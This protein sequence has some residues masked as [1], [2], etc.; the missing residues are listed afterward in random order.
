MRLVSSRIALSSSAVARGRGDSAVVFQIDS[1]S[2]DVLDQ[3]VVV[4][5]N[6]A[7]DDHRFRQRGSLCLR[8]VKNIDRPETDQPGRGLSLVNCWV[9]AGKKSQITTAVKTILKMK[10]IEHGTLTET[11]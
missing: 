10:R 2:N 3:P 1:L 7:G 4:A 9:T 11:I 8:Y 5:A 6:G